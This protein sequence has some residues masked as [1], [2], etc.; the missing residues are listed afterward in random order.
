MPRLSDRDFYERHLLLKQVWQTYP[1]IFADLS[2]IQQRAIHDFF[3]PT[4]ELSQI[5]LR[6]IRR[7]ITK[8]DPKLPHRAGR[9][10]QDLMHGTVLSSVPSRSKIRVVALVRPE[11]DGAKLARAFIEL[12]R[13]ERA[14]AK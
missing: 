12:A 5:E 4:Q 3:H 11:I 6:Q 10:F 14:G 8:A 13:Q 2:F 7:A 1:E 9:A